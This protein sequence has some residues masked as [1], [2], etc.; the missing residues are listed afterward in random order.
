LI[1]EAVPLPS[2]F[3]GIEAGQ[4]AVNVKE[5]IAIDDQMHAINIV[6]VSRVSCPEIIE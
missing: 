2:E 3:G 4:G 1:N 5:I 6:A